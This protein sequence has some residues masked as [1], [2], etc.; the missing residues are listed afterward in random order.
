MGVRIF[1]RTGMLWIHKF[2]QTNKLKYHFKLNSKQQQIKAITYHKYKLK[3]NQACA[4]TRKKQ[5]TEC[6]L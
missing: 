1:F 3:I 5:W 4:Q 2:I 6:R